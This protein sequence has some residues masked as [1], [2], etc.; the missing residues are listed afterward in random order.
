[1]LLS[2]S[3][4]KVGRMFMPEPAVEES[5]ELLRDWTYNLVT[6]VLQIPCVYLVQLHFSTVHF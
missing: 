2:N 1:M 5:Y 6:T 3:V 4:E